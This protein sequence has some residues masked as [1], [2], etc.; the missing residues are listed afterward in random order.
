MFYK[1]EKERC[2][3][4]SLHAACDCHGFVVGVE[5]TGANVHDS[6]MLGPLLNTSI[7]NAGKPDAVAADAGYKTPYIAKLLF[8]ENIRPVLPYTRPKTKDG[9]FKK[10]EYVYDDYYDVYICPEGQLL[11]YSTTD[12]DGYSHYKSNP[13]ECKSCLSRNQCT[14]SQT[15]QKSV[16]RHVFSE[17]LEEAEHLRHTPEN[18][19]IYK[20]RKETIERVFADLKE[21]QGLRYTRLRGI[22]NLKRQ[23]LLAF[24]C[25]NLRKLAKRVWKP[26]KRASIFDHL[27]IYN[28]KKI[29]FPKRMGDFFYKL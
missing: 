24:A 26:R 9:F 28:I 6:V 2:L 14:Q 5:V 12:R 10:Y 11:K 17:Y 25:H 15:M 4:Y 1:N 8:D 7:M 23:A 21:K 29:A 13:R 27:M 22:R 19:M 16:T 20:A 18:K 3:A